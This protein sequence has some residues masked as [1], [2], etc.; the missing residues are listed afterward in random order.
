[1]SDQ[2]PLKATELS[3]LR[4]SMISGVRWGTLSAGVIFAVSLVQTFVLAHLLSP[5]DFGL[6]AASLVVIGLARAFADLGLSSAIV[7]KQMRD[8]NTLS[9]LYWASI[10]AGIVVFAIVLGLMP[11]FVSFYRQ[12]DLYHILPWAALSF[13]IIPIGQQF[14]M[15]LQMDLRVD[16]MVKVDIVSA[17]ASLGVAIGAALAGA[18]PLTLA[19]AYLTRVSVTSALFATW[20]WRH[21]RPKL[22]L[23]RRDLD[24]YLG[25]GLYQMGERMVNFLSANVDY[26]LV[27][28][29]L[30]AGA[31]GSYSVAYQLVVKPVFEFNPIL[32]RVSFPAFAKKQH[33]DEA[34]A[35]GYAE[36][37]KLVGFV[38]VPLM[39]AVAALAPLIVPVLF[40][41]KWDQA[42]P[43]LQILAVVGI[44]RSLTSPAGD[45]ILAK[46]R[47]DI[48]FKL[49]A[50]LLAAMSVAIYVAATN[51]DVIAVAWAS[52]AVNTLDFFVCLAILL[53]L[54]HMRASQYFGALVLSCLNSAA[55]AL[56]MLVL[57]AVLGPHLADVWVLLI[58]G[59]AGAITY[60]GL[61]WL[62]ERRFIEQMLAMLRPA[63]VDSRPA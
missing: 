61:A 55:A 59:G 10:I 25:F 14:Q 12:P 6:M 47:P 52:S 7:A 53:R 58:A 26:I 54:V 21:H 13:V 16:R 1:V 8:P 36:L 30:G 18:G 2:P 38:V 60:L 17:V 29:Y 20:G 35:R 48:N 15:L 11:L 41:S 43:L 44:A 34:L 24:G 28:R 33:D 56:V 42:I 40:G 45:L 22:R 50:F 31:L 23:R 4:R 46:G 37:I 51:Y 32:T 19:F 39:A 5:R 63:R 9:S 57:R 27:G 3:P 62:T 49:N